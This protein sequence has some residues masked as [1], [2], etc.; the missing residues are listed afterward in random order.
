[1]G[2]VREECTL[3]VGARGVWGQELP[4]TCSL[5]M[6]METQFGVNIEAK[7]TQIETI[8]T[9]RWSKSVVNNIS[10]TIKMYKMQSTQFRGPGPEYGNL[11]SCYFK[12]AIQLTL[13][14]LFSIH[15]VTEGWEGVFLLSRKGSG[16]GLDCAPPWEIFL[17]F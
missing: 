11:Q 7:F 9:G 4:K 6:L 12:C 15:R 10:D 17:S 13:N 1:M 8:S 2:G 5:D 3:P 16:E 14:K